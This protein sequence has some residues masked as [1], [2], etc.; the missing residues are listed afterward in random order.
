MAI[1]RYMDWY[2]KESN[3]SNK[4]VG[5]QSVSKDLNMV[6][7]KKSS[8]ARLNRNSTKNDPSTEGNGT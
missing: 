5:K 8:K 6:K 4:Q 2:K 7:P 3:V 1:S